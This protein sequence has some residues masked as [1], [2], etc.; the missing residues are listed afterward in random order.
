MAVNLSMLAGAGAQFFTDSGVPLTGGLIYTYAAGTT[1]PQVA[2]TS[3]SGGTAHSN[4]IV[5]NSA[6]RVASGGE[7]WL[8]DAVAYK[9]VLQT[10]TGVTIATYD[11][12]T[13]NASGI[14][15]SLAASSG[16]SLVGF[17]Q[18]GTGAV[19]T[20]AQAK[21]RQAVSIVDFGA[22]P[23]G[24]SDCSAAILAALTAF[25]TIEIPAGNF[26]ITSQITI[27]ASNKTIR[28]VG[29][30]ITRGASMPLACF[31]GIN[32]TNITV[33][34]VIF[35]VQIGTPHTQVGSFITLNT[36]NFFNVN[37][38]TFDAS[39]PGAST[40]K[41]S[42]FAGVSNKSCNNVSVLGNT[43][44]YIY[45]QAT[46]ADDGTGT[47]VYGQN[48]T[49]TNNMFYNIVDTSVGCFTN[50]SNV[51]IDSNSF[52]RDDYSITPLYNGV[53]VDIA[54][55]SNVVVSNNS[56][57]GN[58]IGVRSLTNLKY[59]NTRVVIEANNFKNQTAGT[60]E[61]AQCIKINHTQ[62]S[63]TPQSMDV[64]VLNNNFYVTASGYGVDIIPVSSDVS[65]N[66][67]LT[68]R[69]D[70]NNFYLGEA[71]AKGIYFQYSGANGWLQVIPGAN[72]FIGSTTTG[73]FG[74]GSSAFTGM[75]GS[76]SFRKNVNA[77]YNIVAHMDSVT[78]TAASANVMLN[79]SG[80]IG[81]YC[82]AYSVSAVTN[83]STNYIYMTPKGGGVAGG[84]P[85]TPT[86]TTA[87]ANT[88]SS[89]FGWNPIE[90]P[91]PY[92]IYEQF[93]STTSEVWDY[94]NVIRLM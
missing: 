19:A 35:K 40:Q 47:G 15:S 7:I 66:T 91:G 77:Q 67:K 30:T 12:V 85:Q 10:S 31:Y 27:P 21:M 6:G 74:V 33:S 22:D 49:I 61:P 53:F 89:E 70:G 46:S 57:D 80:D 88:D 59:T 45:G 36:C 9:F 55:A 34:N 20:T 58:V 86:M 82:I 78:R 29:G 90:T 39:I 38:N 2:Y 13:G 3:S 65:G 42:L 71:S 87:R 52:L 25:D 44:K 62:G 16:S 17:I 1:T 79:F 83:A 73:S 72:N 37:G 69:V 11:N 23:T 26:L 94:V 18:S 93:I 5:L 76:T 92:Q 64:A 60:L 63:G 81:L 54:G 68:V 32:L 41:E 50:C 56:F 24:V 4:P 28:G 48:V 8:T 51:V 84:L 14:V 43:F 75:N